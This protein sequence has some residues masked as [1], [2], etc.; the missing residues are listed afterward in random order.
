MN[1][2]CS[3]LVPSERNP[4]EVRALQLEGAGPTKWLLKN[5]THASLPNVLQDEGRV[6]VIALLLISSCTRAVSPDH[7]AG[8]EPAGGGGMGGHCWLMDQ[9]IN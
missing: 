3:P 2:P 5:C 4:K 7:W 9:S 8:R 6:P 1:S